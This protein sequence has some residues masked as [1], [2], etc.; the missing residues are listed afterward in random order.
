MNKYELEFHEK[1]TYCPDVIV[2]EARTMNEAVNK[3]FEGKNVVVRKASK[4]DII[5]TDVSFVSIWAAGSQRDKY[6]MSHGRY[7]VKHYYIVEEINNKQTK[8]NKYKEYPISKMHHIAIEAFKLQHE[9]D[10][11]ESGGIEPF[12]II[13][14][15]SCRKVNNELQIKIEYEYEPECGLSDNIYHPDTST[16]TDIF[17]FDGKTIKKNDNFIF[18]KAM[19]EDSTNKQKR[20]F[21]KYGKFFPN[22]YRVFEERLSND[23]NYVC[24]SLVGKQYIEQLREYIM[25]DTVRKERFTDIEICCED[26]NEYANKVLDEKLKELTWKE[27]EQIAREEDLTFKMPIPNKNISAKEYKEKVN[28]ED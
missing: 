6:A 22:S 5:D 9:I 4:Q 12:P 25:D 15:T 14:K 16:H 1:E 21:E 7:G 10:G 2:V 11:L 20:F 18:E 26:D 17:T 28:A 19:F 13:T 24:S 3:F 27:L 23:K 8:K